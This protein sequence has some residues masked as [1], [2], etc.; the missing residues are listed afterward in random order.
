M[1][2]LRN[3]LVIILNIL[4]IPLTVLTAAGLVWYSLPMFAT[5]EF[6]ILI[7]ANLSSTAIFW[8]TLGCAIGVIVIYTL[9]LILNKYAPA[10]FKNFFIHLNS[11][12]V[13]IVGVCLSIYTF[14]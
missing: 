14:A 3:I 13:A 1:K 8:I 6:G 11:W 4:S 10:K 5:T 7:T 2:I 9:Q 12:L